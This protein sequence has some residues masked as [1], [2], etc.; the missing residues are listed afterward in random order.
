[1][2]PAFRFLLVAAHFVCPLLFFTNL[3]RNPYVTQIAL[4]NIIMALAAALYVARGAVS[5]TELRPPRT[6]LDGPWAAVAALSLLSWTVAYFGHAAFFRPAIVAEGSRNGMFLLL[7]AM[8][9]FYLS[10]CLPWDDGGPEGVDLGWWSFA[11][12]AWGLLWLMYPALRG[13]PSASAAPWAQLWD[14]YGGAL[15]VAGLA[16]FAWLCRRGRAGDFLHLAL[17]VGFLASVY[18]VCQYFN[19][20]FIWP[21]ALNPYGGRSVSSFGNPNFLSSYNVVLLPIAAALFVEARTSARRLCYGA[22]F[23]ALE[24]AL[25][26]SMTRSSWAGAALGL[27]L[28]ALSPGLRGAAARAARPCG[29]LGAA[30]AAMLLLWPESSISTGYTPSVLGRLAEVSQ[31]AKADAAYSPWHQRVLIWTCAWLMGA[32]NPLTG[33]GYGLFE[34]FYPFYQGPLLGAVEALRHLRTHANNAHNELLET[35][36]QTGILGLGALLWTWTVFAAAAWRWIRSRG[37]ASAAWFGA[38]AGCAGMLAD[39]LFNVSV[40]FAVPGFMFWWAAGLAMGVPAREEGLRRRIA[41]AAARGLAAAAAL[42]AVG[43]S[44]QWVRVWNREVRYFAGFKLL[45]QGDLPRAVKELEASRA[46]GPNEVNAVYELGNAYARSERYP[47]ADRA[48]GEALRANAGY[49]EIY[50]NIA[51]VKS[52]R[53]GQVDA[54]LDYFRVAAWINPMSAEAYN[55]MS[56]ILLQDP[57]RRGG[58][59]REVLERAV[60]MFPR[61]A[62]HWHNLGYLNAVEKRWPQAIAA[63]TRALVEAPDMAASEAGL[64]AAVAAG[65]A[66]RPAI[67]D[68]L[69]ELRGLEARLGRNDLSQASLDIALRLAQRFPEMSKARFL[70]GT[71]LLVR[72]RPAEAAAHLEWVVAREPR[73]VSAL[74]HLAHALIATGNAKA[75]ARYLHQALAA[76]P[77]NAAAKEGLRIL[78]VK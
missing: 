21:T 11:T 6:P 31:A 39:N 26:C 2:T 9:P 12:L 72:N 30:A 53:L 15:W 13:A 74:T 63:Y 61:S 58:E 32:E 75:A 1:M 24:A 71:L 56:A 49:D 59:A 47:D 68:A 40:H 67:L 35:W 45:R 66:P 50:F 41:P 78:G 34:L 77:G 64:S 65:R 69:A 48:Y 36:A 33:Q 22:V 44:W 54:A 46:W 16:A 52:S 3:T 43:L 14:P 37:K 70:A 23:L 73:H 28:L 27:G 76:D 18:G 62:R 5:R 4:L 60:R 42:A 19:H 51:A 25:L 10:A 7:N 8:V 29:L 17:A 55:S 20:E 57:R 38:A